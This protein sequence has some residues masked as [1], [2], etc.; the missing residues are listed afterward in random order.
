MKV[1][2]D[3]TQMRPA[4]VLVAAGLGADTD[5]AHRFPTTL[6]L[7]HPTPDMRVYETSSEQ[8][9]KLVKVTALYHAEVSTEGML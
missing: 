2:Y 1:A 4:C 5:V 8:L 9:D 3:K 7:L 6:W